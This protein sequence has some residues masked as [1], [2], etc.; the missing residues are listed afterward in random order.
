MST[1][2]LKWLEDSLESRCM[3]CVWSMRNLSGLQRIVLQAWKDPEAPCHQD[4]IIHSPSCKV[5]RMR[6]AHRFHLFILYKR[7]SFSEQEHSLLDV[8]S[9]S[10]GR[11]R[12]CSTA[13]VSSA[14]ASL[15]STQRDASLC[16]ARS[17]PYRR[18][19]HPCC[20]FNCPRSQA[21]LDRRLRLSSSARDVR[22]A[23]ASARAYR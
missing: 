15:E 21:P 14:C 12:L 22:F 1:L 13:P 3:R 18:P 19:T 11:R 6:A 8:S 4:G 23:R 5:T 7:K 2:R 16:H 17:L 10:T 9:L 20:A